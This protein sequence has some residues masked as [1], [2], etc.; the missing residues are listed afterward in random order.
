MRFKLNYVLRKAIFITFIILVFPA[1]ITRNALK[2]KSFSVEKKWFADSKRHGKES[3]I[4]Y[5]L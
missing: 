2:Y 5:C 4:V 3:K 1:H